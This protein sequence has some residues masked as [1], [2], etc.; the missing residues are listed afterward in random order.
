MVKTHIVKSKLTQEEFNQKVKFVHG[1]KYDY[2]ETDICE[3]DEKNRV[4]IIC[5][6]HGEFWQRM[7]SHLHG[8]GCKK[9][10]SDNIRFTKADFIKRARK[11]HGDKA[12][13]SEVIYKGYEEKVKIK[14]NVCGEYFY[15]TPHSHLQNYGCPKCKKKYLHNLHVKTTEQVI[16][17]FKEKHGDKYDYSLMDYI[18]GKQKIKII[19]PKHGVFEMT[20]KEHIHGHGC[21]HCNDSKLENNI[22]N[23]LINNQIEFETQKGFDWLKHKRKLKLDFYLP[24]YNVAIECQGGQH[25][26]SVKKWGG[27]SLYEKVKNRDKVKRKLCKEHGIKLL[28]F[29]NLGIDYP[30]EVIE[31]E[32]KLIK[33]IKNA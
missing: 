14:C 8:L 1:D 30:Y 20:P 24:K 33:E 12:D 7:D 9:C 26:K 13:Y 21:P 18:N 32:D 27:D 17:D 23:L 5:P 19:C 29:S 3:R 11:I 10:A 16:S 22:S 2:S 4:K 28:Y 25:F 6:K 15:V 31:D